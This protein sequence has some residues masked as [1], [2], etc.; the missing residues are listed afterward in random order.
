MRALTQKLILTGLFL[1]Y[2]YLLFGQWNQMDWADVPAE[3]LSMTVYPMDSSAKA[4]VLA[5][6]GRIRMIAGIGDNRTQYFLERHRRVKLLKRQAFDE[7]GRM[8]L[9]FVHRDDRERIEEFQA[10]TILP[11]GKVYRVAAKDIFKTKEN[12]W[13][14]SMS[15]AF[16][17]LEE[18][19]IVEFKYQL[20]SADVIEPRPW[21]FQ[22][23][24]PV[25]FS[26]L[27]IKNSSRIS[28]VSLFNGGEHYPEKEEQGTVTIYR[29]GETSLHYGPELIMM[30]NAPALTKEEFI[31]TLEDYRAKIRLQGEYYFTRGGHKENLFT[32]WEKS[33][34][35]LL[36]H[37]QFGQ[38]FL[39]KRHFK[40]LSDE[41]NPLLSP[42]MGPEEIMETIYEFV[43]QNVAFD[44]KK[45]F[46]VQENLNKAFVQKK[47]NAGEVNLMCLAL[48]K[49]N[50]LEAFPILTS[51][52]DHGK[53]Y[54]HYPLIDQFN[55]LIVGVKIGEKVI[56]LDATD[57][58][59]TINMPSPM[60]LNK[61]GWVVDK[62]HL[63]WID[64]K[65]PLCRD[66]YGSEL[67]IDQDGN[68]EG[69]M[70]AMFNSYTALVERKLH[71][72]D[73][74]GEYWKRRMEDFATDVELES[75]EA[76]DVGG[77][78]GKFMNDILFSV[79]NGAMAAGDY[80]YVS[81]IYYSNFL[82]NPFQLKQREY[83][84][85]FPYPFEERYVVSVLVPDGYQ[86]EE[87]P[88]SSESNLPNNAGKF[89]YKT[90][91]LDN[92]VQVMLTLTLNETTFAPESYEGLKSLFEQMISR[93]SE[94]IVLK[95][96]SDK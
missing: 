65:V 69:K 90:S 27:V 57:P 85:D 43:Q 66:I 94:Q 72:D 87:L 41:V 37:P 28:Y 64:I 17:N 26:S 34:Q 76:K 82:E 73:A 42:E 33:A 81:P 61:Y 21:Y 18:G 8:K 9:F 78:S 55:Y 29:N 16:P 80:L 60:A 11:N 67:K 30:K 3:D 47:G 79:P 89:E 71:R 59:Q 54:R 68:I 92:K 62:E 13:L 77:K 5:D 46:W 12:E 20:A 44:G 4:V 49:A 6:C 1:I 75:V 88:E 19:A 95:K 40:K 50:E 52:R 2:S 74:T 10:Q 45:S 63:S 93:R 91:H 56:L 25:R 38:Q 86:V 70:R 83:P 96:I 51:T 22:E 31:T 7:Y 39:K 24:I 15:F 14:S 36:N 84:V 48:L 35:S 53:M 32:S 58:M 23:E